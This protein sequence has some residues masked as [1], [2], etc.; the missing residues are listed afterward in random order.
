M[1]ITY[2]CEQCGNVFDSEEA[3]LEH[4]EQCRTAYDVKQIQLR[5]QYTDAKY[6]AYRFDVSLKKWFNLYKK[7]K[8][9]I[10]GGS[11][12]SSAGIGDYWVFTA[13]LSEDKEKVLKKRLL[14]TALEHGEA[15]ITRLQQF[16]QS[17]K[18]LEKELE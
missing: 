8:E 7:P 9:D 18:E 13:D 1:K 10:M 4:E 5:K 12:S 16:Q 11:P 6:Y 17:A 14:T 2:T 15:A 3:A